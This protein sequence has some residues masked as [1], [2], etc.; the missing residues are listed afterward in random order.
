M[1]QVHAD[2]EDRWFGATSGWLVAE[3]IPVGLRR[4]TDEFEAYAPESMLVLDLELNLATRV[5]ISRRKAFSGRSLSGL[6][7]QL[8]RED[9]RDV[10]FDGCDGSAHSLGSPSLPA[11][12]WREA[13]PMSVGLLKKRE[14]LL[15][16]LF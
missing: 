16:E 4:L 6:G 11:F 3:S 9:C 12:T 8:L 15:V 10:M 1:R 7:L 5:G 14:R 13:C 2:V